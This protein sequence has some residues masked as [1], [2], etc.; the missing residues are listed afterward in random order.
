MRYPGVECADI[1]NGMSGGHSAYAAIRLECQPMGVL[2]KGGRGC[3]RGLDWCAH[4]KQTD[5]LLSTRSI[6]GSIVGE[7]S[8][9]LES[10]CRDHL[11][12]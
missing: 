7:S 5:C 10:E 6:N 4:T 12:R 2:P 8:G 3:A 11:A 1:A 9:V